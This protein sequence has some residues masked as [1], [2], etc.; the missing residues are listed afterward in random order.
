MTGGAAIVVGQ[1]RDAEGMLGIPW[2]GAHLGSMVHVWKHV[3]LLLKE[4]LLLL[5]LLLHH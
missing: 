3:L 1:L 5:L 4:V 2:V